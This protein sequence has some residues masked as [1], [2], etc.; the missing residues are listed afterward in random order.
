MGMFDLFVGSLKCPICNLISEENIQ[1]KIRENP[2]WS[3]F[4]V[5]DSLEVISAL[6]NA[7]DYSTLQSPL[8]DQ[9][10]HLLDVWDCPNGHVYNW[11]Q[12]AVKGGIIQNLSAVPKSREILEKDHFINE[13]CIWGLASDAGYI[14][15][16][17]V[18][19]SLT[20]ADLDFQKNLLSTLIYLIEIIDHKKEESLKI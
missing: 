20:I 14:Q 3:Y 19:G 7:G 15:K 12:I 10:I 6:A 17:P 16:D 11:V 1:T 18:S 13:E 4:H 9:E 2:D 5:G 8:V